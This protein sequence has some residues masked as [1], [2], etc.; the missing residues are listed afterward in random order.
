MISLPMDVIE[1]ADL[2]GAGHL[3]KMFRVVL[4]MVRTTVI[5]VAFVIAVQLFR[6]FDL[7]YL[8]TKGGPIGATTIST[9]YVFIQ[10][11]VNNE[12]GYSNALGIVLVL[13]A[14][15]PQLWSRHRARV[16]AESE[17]PL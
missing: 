17:N 7:V 8:L 5:L 11:F 15:I 3:V 10:G 13:L 4:P 6:S 9:L 2:D 12:Y 16:Q 14:L 1:A